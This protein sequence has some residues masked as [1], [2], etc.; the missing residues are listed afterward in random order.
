MIPFFFLL[1][2][3]IIDISRVVFAANSLNNGAREGARFASVGNPPPE[4]AGMTRQV[5]AQTVATNRSWGVDRSQLT[6][7]VTCNR[8]DPAGGGLMSPPPPVTDCRTNDLI[9]VRTQAPFRLVTPIIA[10][11]LGPLTLGGEAEVAVN[12]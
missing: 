9:E 5:C 12:Q 7:T 2:F 4:C 8:V 11:V 3:G 1:L 10:Q 6:V